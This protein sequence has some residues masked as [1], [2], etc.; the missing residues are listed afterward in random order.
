MSTINGLPA[1][2]L[3]VHAIV[4]LVPLTAVLAVLCALWQ[5]ARSR[6][7]W[8]TVALS[9]I[10][11]ALTPV[12]TDAGEWLGDK[13]GWSPALRH[14]QQ[15]GDQMLYFVVPLLIS[16][17][18]LGWLHV[19][20]RRGRAVGRLPR[21]LLAVLVIAVAAAAT[22]QTYRVGDSGAHAVWTGVGS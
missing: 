2:V 21:V 7:I 4:V 1:H 16:A 12:T 11:V 6:L 17:L 14:H 5:A 9:A 3:L 15:L 13:L 10:V 20:E 22:W 19:W 18:L 8:L